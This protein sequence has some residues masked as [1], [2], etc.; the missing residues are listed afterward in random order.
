[1]EISATIGNKE[2]LQLNKTAFLC[3]RQIPATIV[4]KCYDWAIEQREK[5]NCIISGFHSP[6]E[7]DILHYLL[8]G[9]Q[10][11]IVALARGLKQRIEPEF[12]KPIEQGRLLIVSPFPN[13]IKRVTTDTAGIR[14]KFMLEMADVIVIGYLKKDGKLEKIL[15]GSNKVLYESKIIATPFN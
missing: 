10:P 15:K 13:E 8:K 14:N 4:L 6:I 5:G 1:M 7:K 11:I 9:K 12:I 2:I 3:S